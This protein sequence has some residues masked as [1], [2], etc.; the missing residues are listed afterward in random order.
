M[1]G[2]ELVGRELEHVHRGRRAFQQV[3]R[4][5]AEVAAD[6][7]F[8]ARGLRELADQ[9][10]HRA[11]AVG[12]GDADDAAARLAR[13]QLDVADQVEAARRGLAQERLRQRHARGHDHLVR[14]VEDRGIEAA[15]RGRGLRHEAAQFG[16]P[17]RRRAR[18]GDD[19]AVAARREMARAGHAGAAEADDDA[20][21]MCGGG[22]HQ[23]SFSVASPIRTSMKEMIQ[24]R[25]MTFGSAQPFSS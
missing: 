3:E 25:T 14:A 13:E 12:A 1:R 23:R 15:E 16:E 4:R 9:R 19:Q 24:K 21:R 5:H 7:H 11:L 22:L 18:V 17:G 8:D 20:L 2:L 6:P 10:R